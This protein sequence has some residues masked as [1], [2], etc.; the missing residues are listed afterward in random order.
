M[1]V[2]VIIVIMT[3]TKGLTTLLT[4]RVIVEAEEEINS[5]SRVNWLTQWHQNIKSENTL[6]FKLKNIT[7]RYLKSHETFIFAMFI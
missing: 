2:F 5:P 7:L 1:T 3:V 4:I 6:E